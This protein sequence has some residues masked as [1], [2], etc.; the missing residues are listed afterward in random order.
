MSMQY[1]KWIALFVLFFGIN[2]ADGTA[3]AAASNANL[4]IRSVTITLGS[5]SRDKL[6]EQLRRFA[7][8]NAFAIRIAPTNPDN[9]RFLVQIWREDIKGVGT[10]AR[11]T[12][13]FSIGLYQNCDEPVPAA[14]ANE[15]VDELR[16]TVGQVPG[17]TFSEKQ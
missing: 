12:K 2:S 9:E 13:T 5:A 16:R 7:D 3:A 6:F 8:T 15:V 10:N 17:A 11:S 14:I 1:A 4:P